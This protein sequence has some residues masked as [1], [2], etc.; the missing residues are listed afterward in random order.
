VRVLIVAGVQVCGA[1][2]AGRRADRRSRRG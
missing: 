2:T 1:A